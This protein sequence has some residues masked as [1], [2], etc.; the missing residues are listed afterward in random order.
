VLDIVEV[1]TVETRLS[2]QLGFGM[3]YTPTQNRGVGVLLVP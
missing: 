2:H 3:F 1:M